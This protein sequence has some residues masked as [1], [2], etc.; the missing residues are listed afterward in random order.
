MTGKSLPSRSLRGRDDL[1]T[2]PL[3]LSAHLRA[4]LRVTSSLNL[5]TSARVPGGVARR[6]GALYELGLGGG[7]SYLVS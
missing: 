5:V 4:W 2:Q 6:Q 7:E 1:Y 3:I